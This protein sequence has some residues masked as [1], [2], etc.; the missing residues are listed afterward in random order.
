MI[1]KE[2]REKLNLTQKQFS[3]KLGKSVRSV[4]NYELGSTTPDG[5][6]MLKYLSMLNND[7]HHLAQSFDKT[8]ESEIIELQKFKI[9]TLEKDLKE[10]REELFFKGKPIPRND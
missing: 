4:Q 9:Q 1:F 2:I 8:K 6:T 10:C 3:E 5:K 7:T